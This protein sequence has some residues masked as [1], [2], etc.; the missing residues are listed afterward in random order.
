[1]LENYA[2]EC[3]W[4]R[5]DWVLRKSFDALQVDNQ[6]EFDDI[7][8]HSLSPFTFAWCS[9]GEMDTLGGFLDS[10]KVRKLISRQG[11]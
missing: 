4:R 11:G 9:G 1:M 5:E 6:Y 3:N 7:C 10:R 8:F 2:R